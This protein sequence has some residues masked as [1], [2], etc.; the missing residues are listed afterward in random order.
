MK[1]KKLMHYIN[2]ANQDLFSPLIYKISGDNH[3]YVLNEYYFLFNSDQ[4]LTGGSYNFDFDDNNIPIVKGHVSDTDGSYFY[5]PQAI[6]QFALALYHDYIESKNVK[7]LNEFLK[8]ADWFK[9][10]YKNFRGIPHWES[11]ENRIFRVYKD[12]QR[13]QV[14]SSMSQSRAISVLLR[15][16][17]HTKERSYLNLVEKA[18]VAYKKAPSE[19]GFLDTNAEGDIFFEEVSQPR[20][21]NHLIFSLFGLFDYCR[22]K[23]FDTEYYDLF[24]ESVE[25]IKRHLHVYDNGW[26]SLYDNY[27]I[28]GNRRI[29]PCTRHYHYIHIKQLKVL[30]K[31]TGDKVFKQYY[32]RWIE[33]DKSIFRRIK[34]LLYKMRTVRQM[35]RI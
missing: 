26:W 16:F 17:Q 32:L 8:L 13:G 21:L 1:I 7:Y 24:K 22:V 28:K 10:S 27:F 29:N 11:T 2:K 9:E 33:Y 5:Q 14:I 23:K 19:G 3:S 34:M 12:D 35:G 30:Y 6:G 18:I 15:A 25:T 31:I 4:L 20:I